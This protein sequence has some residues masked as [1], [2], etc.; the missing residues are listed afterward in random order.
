M[1][2]MNRSMMVYARLLRR[3][4]GAQHRHVYIF[5]GAR[6]PKYPELEQASDEAVAQAKYLIQMLDDRH[7]AV[8]FASAVGM[9]GYIN[10]R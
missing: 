8:Q 10:M 3:K 5:D 9:T 4:I 7:L 1:V 6:Y 2:N